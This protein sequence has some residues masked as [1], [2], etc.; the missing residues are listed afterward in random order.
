MALDGIIEGANILA[1][2]KVTLVFKKFRLVVFFLSIML[3]V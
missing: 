2:P 3:S 1:I